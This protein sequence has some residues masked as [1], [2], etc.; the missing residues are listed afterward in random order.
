MGV[1]PEYMLASSG[2]SPFYGASKSMAQVLA[3]MT[4]DAPRPG[5]LPD[6]WLMRRWSGWEVWTPY[7]W[8]PRAERALGWQHT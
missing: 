5:E 7:D 2:E 3:R 8:V 4:G 6:G 1:R